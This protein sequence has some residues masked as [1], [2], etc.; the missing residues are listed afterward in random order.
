MTLYDHYDEKFYFES[1]ED[2]RVKNKALFCN[3]SRVLACLVIL[4]VLF[5]SHWL[6]PPTVEQL[7]VLI[8]MRLPPR[9][10]LTIF[11]YELKQFKLDAA[12]TRA[13]KH[14]AAIYRQRLTREINTYKLSKQI[15]LT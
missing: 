3:Y 15:M 14:A 11:Q 9:Q 12:S 1:Y 8:S 5:T 2:V 13:S 7:S 4:P 6:L 10:S